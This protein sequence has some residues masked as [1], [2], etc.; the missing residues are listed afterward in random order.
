MKMEKT[1]LFYIHDFK[2][3]DILKYTFENRGYNVD[4]AE[5][6]EDVIKKIEK[7]VYIWCV[8]DDDN[9]PH[10]ENLNLDLSEAHKVRT[11]LRNMIRE[12]ETNLM[13]LSYFQE[14]IDKA[15]DEGLSAMIK[16]EFDALA[17]EFIGKKISW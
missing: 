10:S 1:A 11:V 8:I 6:V 5:S 17:D 7:R 16:S 2:C 15:N 3:R 9:S 12:G 13:F 4:F 14:V